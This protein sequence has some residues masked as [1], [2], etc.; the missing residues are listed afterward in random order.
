MR[1]SRKYARR[2]LKVERYMFQ[3][4]LKEGTVVHISGNAVRVI[5]VGFG[6]IFFNYLENP[7]PGPIQTHFEN[8]DEYPQEK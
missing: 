2:L 7:F 6:S 8:I 1:T 5:A 3:R 4:R